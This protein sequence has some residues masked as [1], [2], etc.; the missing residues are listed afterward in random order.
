[1]VGA[2]AGGVEALQTLVSGL[3]ADL[4]AAVL[5]VLHLPR[6]A[7]SA[8]PII[9]TRA[10]PLPAHAARDDE[11]IEPGH[12]YVAPA[13]HHLLV[14]DDRVRLSSG[15]AENGHRPGI[16]ALFRSA[17]RSLGPRVLGVVLSGA[18]DDGAAGLAAIELSGGR[19]VVQQPADA[20]YPSMPKA[21]LERV[22]A[23]AAVVSVAAMGDTIAKLITS[24]ANAPGPTADAA[25]E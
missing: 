25:G 4:P 12:I 13:D 23:P 11:P 5:V 21:A 14:V 1:M 9:L 3:P 7:P 18:R 24:T 19:C 10:G 22:T 8:L 16:D 20:R 2:S 6:A 17:A 15:P